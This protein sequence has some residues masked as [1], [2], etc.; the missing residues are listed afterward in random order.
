VPVGHQS[1]GRRWLHTVPE[2]ADPVVKCGPG[3]PLA[4]GW[5]GRG[6]LAIDVRAMLDTGGL[7]RVVA[8]VRLTVPVL[9]AE[10]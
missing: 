6:R 3:R 5:A 7:G 8:S 10:E 1:L 9:E 2:N 4:F